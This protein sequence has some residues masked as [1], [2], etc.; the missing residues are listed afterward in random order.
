MQAF[1]GILEEKIF[2]LETD[3]NPIVLGGIESFWKLA[4]SVGLMPLFYFVPCP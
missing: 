4:L 1:Q 3:L 2:K